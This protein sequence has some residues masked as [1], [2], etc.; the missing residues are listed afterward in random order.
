MKFINN[1][2][3]WAAYSKAVAIAIGVVL[4]A[5]S[6]AQLQAQLQQPEVW[7]SELLQGHE[8]VGRIWSEELQDFV[9]AEQL[10]EVI[11]GARYLL[12]GEKHDNPDHHALQL[13]ILRFLLEE[14][15]LGLLTLEMMDES[16]AEKLQALPDIDTMSATEL[17]TYLVWDDAGWDWEFYGP[18]IEAAYGE[19]IELRAGNISRATVSAVYADENSIDV[20]GV[21]SAAAEEQLLIDIDESHCGQL[22]ESQFPAMFR[23][24]Q[25]RDKAM[26]ESMLSGDVDG[27]SVLIAGNYHVRHDL[28][29]PNYLLAREADLERSHIVSIAAMEVSEGETDPRDYQQLLEVQAAYDYLWFTPALTSEDYCASLRSSQ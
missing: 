23:V 14:Q 18:L 13:T 21:L 15:R 7:Q 12:L 5:V 2:C 3:K 8:L 1:G 27:V 22:P 28:G 24:Q 9:T 11:L 17:K 20:S 6:S 4:G 25:A 10:A 19:G 16:A 29:V 26:A